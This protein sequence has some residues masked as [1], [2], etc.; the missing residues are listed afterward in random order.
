MPKPIPAAWSVALALCLAGCGGEDEKPPLEG[1]STASA[2]AS[3]SSLRY[4]SFGRNFFTTYCLRCHSSNAADR[5]GAPT[6]LNFDTVEQIRMHSA[7]IDE[8]AAAGPNVENDAMP[9]SGLI[10]EYDERRDLGEWLAC[11]AP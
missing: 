3:G 4:S 10:P 8:L 2:C 1:Q 7:R 9:P 5:R 11:G 6:S